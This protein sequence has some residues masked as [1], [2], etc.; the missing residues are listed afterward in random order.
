MT[1]THWITLAAVCLVLAVLAPAAQAQNVNPVTSP[2]GKTRA[3]AKDSTITLID[4]ASGKELRSFRGHT[5]AV[6]AL[7]FSP[8]GRAL[9]SGGQDNTIALWDLATGRLLAKIRTG[10]AITALTYSPDGKTLTSRE[11]D[12]SKKVFDAATGKRLE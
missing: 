1:R 2:D 8:D 11:A 10:V 9:A 4:I 3:Q 7:A 6:S 5:G 12:K